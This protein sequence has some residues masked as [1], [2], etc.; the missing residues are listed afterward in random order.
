M[1]QLFLLEL[2][3]LFRSNFYSDRLGGIIVHNL[4]HLLLAFL[5]LATGAYIALPVDG[6]SL[7]HEIE[8]RNSIILQ[9]VFTY[10]ALRILAENSSCFDYAPL[11]TLPVKRF[12]I[13]AFLT[14]K[15]FL[16]WYNIYPLIIWWGIR[17]GNNDYASDFVN[18]ITTGNILLATL[19]SHLLTMILR[20]G[21][22]GA[23]LQRGYR[24]NLWLML[25]GIGVALYSVYGIQEHGAN[26]ADINW[27]A[28]NAYF[29]V[30][31]LTGISLW[32]LLKT[33]K[34]IVTKY[35][36]SRSILTELFLSILN[37]TPSSV[38]N[39]LEFFLILR[40]R[41]PRKILMIAMIYTGGLLY[42][43]NNTLQN[44]TAGDPALLVIFAFVLPQLIYGKFFLAWHGDSIHLLMS[45]PVKWTDLIKHQSYMLTLLNLMVWVGIIGVAKVQMDWVLISTALLFYSLGINQF[46][47]LGWG[48]FVQK[49]ISPNNAHLMGSSAVKASEAALI[50]LLI[51]PPIALYLM[52]NYQVSNYAAVVALWAIGMVAIL[53]R[54]HWLEQLAM[55]YVKKKYHL[56]KYLN[57]K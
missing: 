11:L 40:N 52:L 49:S 3:E 35:H 44:N 12:K 31:I 33:H 28:F 39:Q 7:L 29:L 37:G 14:I 27:A 5:L 23:L 1:Y 9:F 8:Y 45:R 50:M 17:I 13:F 22:I 24:K 25:A 16:S 41:Q 36:A 10:T 4:I 34:R 30:F 57:T 54:N 2:K 18:E 48:L 55:A 42:F 43:F 20:L 56:I 38:Y 32:I 53:L 19:L 6:F 15:S 47:L 21:A 51:I 46:L 26:S